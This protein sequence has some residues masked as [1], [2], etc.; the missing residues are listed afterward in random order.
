[1]EKSSV[2]SDQKQDENALFIKRKLGQGKYS[3]YYADCPSRKTSYALKIFP[4]N[5][6][7]ILQF[8]KEKLNSKLHHPNVIQYIPFQFDSKEFYGLATEFAPY[9]DLFEWMINDAFTNDVLIRTYFHQLIQGLEYIHSKGIAHLDIKLENLMIGEEFKLKIIDFDQA[10]LLKDRWIT[11]GG[12]LCYR[13]PEVVKK[14]CKDLTAVDI[15]SAGVTLYC[16]VTKEYPFVQ[17]QQYQNKKLTTYEMFAQSKEDF[18]K[19]KTESLKNK[20]EFLNSSFIELM[21]GMLEPKPE[22]RIK[23]Q[24]IKNSK[25]YQGSVLDLESLKIEMK[26]RWEI[27]KKNTREVQQIDNEQFVKKTWN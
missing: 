24:E 18:W 22:K 13:A 3:V 8:N 19:E 15:Y 16:L 17:K 21:N 5:L 1:M 10:Q 25:W 11:S 26:N 23:I 2:L 6:Q 7:G 27:M 12:T 4:R 20:K 9:G 14:V